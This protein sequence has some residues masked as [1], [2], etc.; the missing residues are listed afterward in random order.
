MLCLVVPEALSPKDQL[1]AV[2]MWERLFFLLL[3]IKFLVR[4]GIYGTPAM[5]QGSPSP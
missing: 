2:C 5:Q 4:E 3:S 1:N